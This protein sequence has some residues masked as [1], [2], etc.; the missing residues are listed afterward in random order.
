MTEEAIDTTLEYIKSSNL[1]LYGLEM[2]DIWELLHLLL[3]NVFEYGDHFYR[4]T[5]GLAMGKCLS[6][7][8]AILCMDRFERSHIYNLQPKPI[9][10]VRYVDDTG[11]VVRD[12]G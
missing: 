4:Q 9:F 7:T 5:R 6:G 3:D 8:L 1:Y 2:Q 11:T 12:I 10:Y